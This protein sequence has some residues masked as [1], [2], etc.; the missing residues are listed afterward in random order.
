[1][2][3][4]WFYLRT[5][6]AVE[7]ATAAFPVPRWLL[8][9]A[10]V[11]IGR[12]TGFYPATLAFALRTVARSD[13]HSGA[14]AIIVGLGLALAVQSISV[15]PD[16]SPVPI[17]Q[18]SA[19]LLIVYSMVMGLRL[20]FG[21]PADIRANW[22]FRLTTD[23]L[24]IRPERVV[25]A[26]MYLFCAIPVLTSAAII[27]VFHGAQ[28]ALM[29]LTFSL[30]ASV[31]LIDGVT[32]DFRVVPFTCPW[33]PGRENLPYTLALFLAGMAAFSQLLAAVDLFLMQDPPRLF[34]YLA[35]SLAAF[36]WLRRLRAEDHE[37]TVWSD[38]RGEFDLLRIA[39]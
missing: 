28:P 13:R 20:C 22:I 7:G 11:F 30:T 37:P 29:H 17:G 3:Y 5:S 12:R 27:S 26:V 35:L 23:E 16:T 24:T 1:L 19:T 18:L 2:T 15:S 9:L 34:V 21:I 25:R 8:S 39:E 36:L 4:Q 31:L 33:L 38:T 32:A 14:F 6:E 10:G